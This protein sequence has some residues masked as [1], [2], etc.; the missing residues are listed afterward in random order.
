MSL[1][2]NDAVSIPPKKP[3]AIGKEASNR[4]LP[5]FLYKRGMWFSEAEISF[6][7]GGCRKKEVFSAY[8]HQLRAML[9][10]RIA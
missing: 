6:I 1:H 5:R 10:R 3:A 7:N 8:Q 9:I 4:C 2:P